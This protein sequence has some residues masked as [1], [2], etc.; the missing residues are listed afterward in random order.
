M[1]YEVVLTYILITILF[2]VLGYFVIKYCILDNVAPFVSNYDGNNYEVREIGDE[3]I[4]QTAANYLALIN[5]KI[6]TLVNYMEEHNEPDSD[7]A[8]RLYTRW[9]NCEL[10]ETNSSE[11]SA[12]YTLNKST[13]IRLCIRT[14]DGKFE[15]PNTT[16][17]VALHELGHMASLS[18]GHNEEFK[19]KFV[20]LTHLASKLGLY[21]PEDFI[22][23]PKTYCGVEI[24]TTPCINGSCEYKT[25]KL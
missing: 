4:K 5:E 6:D 1:N 7:T 13:E 18:Y 16:M 3:T 10:K 21:K 11:K 25:I 14:M 19:E 23:N 20:F 9:N 8:N 22:S 12:A 24:N 15:N 17:F 2:V